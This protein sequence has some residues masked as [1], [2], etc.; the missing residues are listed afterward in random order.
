MRAVLVGFQTALKAEACHWLR[1]IVINPTLNVSLSLSF[2]LVQVSGIYWSISNFDSM[3]SLPRITPHF[4]N[5]SLA[6]PFVRMASTRAATIKSLD[7]WVLFLFHFH[8]HFFINFPFKSINSLFQFKSLGSQKSSKKPVNNI[9]IS[10]VLTVASI[11][12]TKAWYEQNLGMRAESFVSAATADITRH[13]LIFG[14]QKINLHE[15][16]KVSYSFSHDVC[17]FMM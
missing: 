7:Q 6:Y 15:L 17:G 8:F 1:N 3:T 12:K 16:G 4:L 5:P 14:Q 13:S 10:I 2:N 11:P 9:S